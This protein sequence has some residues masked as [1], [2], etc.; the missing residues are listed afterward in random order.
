MKKT[1]G[2]ISIFLVLVLLPILSIAS[3][4]VD[5]SR[6]NLAKSMAASAG[7]LTLNTALTNYDSELKTIYGLFATAQNMDEMMESL[8]EYYRQSIVAAGV[9]ESFATDFAGNLVNKLKEET[10]TDDIMQIQLTGLDVETPKGAHLAN[11]AILKSQI[12]EFMKYRAPVNLGMGLIDSLSSMKNLKKQMDVVENK[13]KFYEQHQTMLG[14][15]E[16]AWKDIQVYQF[17]D[18]KT[19]FPTGKYIADK[20]Q[21]LEDQLKTSGGYT[22]ND[23]VKEAVRYLYDRDN[24]QKINSDISVDYKC[25][26]CK[27]ASKK[28]ETSCGSCKASWKIKTAN[29]VWKTKWGNGQEKT[30]TPA[31]SANKKATIDDVLNAYN[32][33][34]SKLDQIKTFEQNQNSAHNIVYNNV[35]KDPV[36]EIY[37]VC[38]LNRSTKES[39]S[40]LQAVK[41]LVQLLVNLSSALHT[42]EDEKLTTTMMKQGS[43]GQ[44]HID[45][46][47]GD[48]NLYSEAKSQ[49][50]AHMNFNDRGYF[51]TFQA[52][53]SKSNGYVDGNAKKVSDSEANVKGALINARN[54]AKPFHEKIVEKIKDLENAIKHLEA[55]QKMLNG[56]DVSADDKDK[57]SYLTAQ[58]NWENSAKNLG[59]DTMGQRDSDELKELKEIVTLDKVTDM[60]TRLT[61]AK[62]SLDEVKKQIESYSI[63]GIAWKD[64]PENATYANMVS[65]I[66]NCPDKNFDS[67]IKGIRPTAESSYDTVINQIRETIQKGNI[68][69]KWEQDKDP[70]LA[71]NAPKLYAW[72]RR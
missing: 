10:G 46:K 69:T 60:I 18:E 14:H 4:M 13:N 19:G 37:A 36:V 9:D 71:P 28:D 34:R 29:Q 64:I 32:K 17:K 48:K 53:I 56:T 23:A 20:K 49:L 38:Q 8:E 45:D 16:E 59:D 47:T 43:T 1:R 15:L 62:T 61:A 39:N 26:E 41:D 44:F 35:S 22:L 40:Y 25:P 31:F 67:T 5:M 66:K 72:L 57:V 54:A 51:Q 21:V 63:C 70:N 50:T 30:V 24:F 65:M 7:D 52:V 27:A 11:P 3:L 55:A 68:P 2:A 12:V 42:C 33:V 58:S 6:L